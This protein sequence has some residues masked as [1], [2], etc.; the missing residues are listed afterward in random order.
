MRPPSMWECQ[1]PSGLRPEGCCHSIW[2]AFGVCR[3][4]EWPEVL[5]CVPLLAR[6]DVVWRSLIAGWIALGELYPTICKRHA[7]DGRPIG[8][9]YTR[10][11]LRQIGRNS[12]TY[13]T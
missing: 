11:C 3:H 2:V 6:D 10:A 4:D 7:V 12:Q 1:K 13:A 8:K 5:T 9:R